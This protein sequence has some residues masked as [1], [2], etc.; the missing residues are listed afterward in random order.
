M[1]HMK[2]G[3]CFI[4][5]KPGHR[6]SDHKGGRTP[7][8]SPP[9]SPPSNSNFRF[10]LKKT[11]AGAFTTIKADMA[12]LDDEEKGKALKLLEEAGF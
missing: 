4:C 3:L 12:D 7:P 8:S 11:G 2:K 5:H 9:Y 1:E 10:T 6:S